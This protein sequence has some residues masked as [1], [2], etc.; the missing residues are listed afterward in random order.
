MKTEKLYYADAYIKE[1][2]AT[3]L[4]CTECEGGFDII[5]D[6]SAFFPEEGGQ[7]SDRGYI[8]DAY[9]YDVRERDKVIHHYAKSAVNVNETLHCKLDFEERFDKM[10]QH[11]A[12][13]IISGILHSMYG[14]EN[15]GFHLGAELVTLDTSRPVSAQELALVEERVNE[16]IQKNVGIRAYFP[17]ESELSVIE[18]RSKLELT[19]DVR[20]VEIE[21]YDRCACCAPHVN[22]SGEIGQLIFVDSVKH[23]GGSRITM[24]AGMRAYKYVRNILSEASSVSVRLSAPKTMIA[25]EV[26]K[27][28]SSKSALEYKINGLANSLAELYAASVTETD[29]NYVF[30]SELL[31][32]DALRN[33]MNIARRKIGGIFV[34][35]VGEENNYRYIL[36]SDSESFKSIVSDANAA[37]SGRGGG[38]APMASGSFAATLQAIRDHFA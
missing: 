36:M 14:I 33:F 3:V 15:T 28:L 34:G 26:D 6:K 32:F 25:S 29:G 11:T 22:Y 13:H 17:A 10:Q 18:Y 31:D 8:A 38:R 27:L 5:L 9:V 35:L 19:E 23:K 20:I 37:L 12:E 30:C 7:Y 4:S 16:A 2:D 21:G 24:L 1:F